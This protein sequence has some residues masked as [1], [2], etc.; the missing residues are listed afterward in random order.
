MFFKDFI[1]FKLSNL[2]AYRYSQNYLFNVYRKDKKDASNEGVFFCVEIFG[3]HLTLFVASFI[4]E[5]CL[6]ALAQ[7]NAWKGMVEA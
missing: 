2:L 1:S 4:I 7:A 3:G 6:R 5:V